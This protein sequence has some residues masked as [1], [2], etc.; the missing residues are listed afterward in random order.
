[1]A[2][3]LLQHPILQHLPY[4]E[5]K[6][7]TID[8]IKRYLSIRRRNFRRVAVL[9]TALSVAY[10]LLFWSIGGSISLDEV[11]MSALALLL[12]ALSILQARK[13]ELSDRQIRE[14]IDNATP[15]TGVGSA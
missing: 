8:G 9:L 15:D 10:P 6:R 7:P 2:S 4:E 14:A 3:S 5:L 1:M 11:I 12:A 13:A